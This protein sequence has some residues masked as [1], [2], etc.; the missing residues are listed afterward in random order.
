MMDGKRFGL[1][2]AAGILLALA[3]VTVS[4]GLGSSPLATFGP[5]RNVAST[6]TVASATITMSTSTVTE[7]ATSTVSMTSTTSGSP[8]Q[9]LVSNKTYPST[10]SSS[11]TTES[12]ASSIVAS[13]TFGSSPTSQ[14]AG[15]SAN[16]GTPYYNLGPSGT[17]KPTQLASIAQQP[18]V[19]NAEILAPV[20]VA[21]LLGAFLYRVVVQEKERSSGD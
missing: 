8:G 13:I 7:T 15:T 6:T 2:L 4:G 9:S 14:S 19:S 3:V 11:G 16:G 1:G 10:V 12:S 18:V 21:F 20:L 17:T 5:A